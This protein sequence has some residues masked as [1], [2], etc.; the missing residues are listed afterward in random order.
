L[1]NIPS[2]EN[3]RKDLEWEIEAT[4]S[5]MTIA[6][7]ADSRLASW[8][9]KFTISGA[10]VFWISRKPQ[11]RKQSEDSEPSPTRAKGISFPIHVQSRRYH[12]KS[13]MTSTKTFLQSLYCFDARF[14][15]A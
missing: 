13:I 2:E 5:I 12:A 1:K 11:P 4:R 14:D 3:Q 9:E 6:R 15:R 10:G 8:Y 7:L